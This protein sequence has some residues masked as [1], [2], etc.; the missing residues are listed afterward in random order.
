MNGGVNEGMTASPF[1]RCSEEV[2]NPL[3]VKFAFVRQ[4]LPSLTVNERA[5]PSLLTGWDGMETG[6]EDMIRDRM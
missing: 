1:P 2:R 6:L 3:T 4:S 5:I